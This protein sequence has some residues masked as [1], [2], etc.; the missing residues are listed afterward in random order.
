ME[1]TYFVLGMLTIAATILLTAVVVGLVKINKLTKQQETIN[2][3]YHRDIEDLHRYIHE[4]RT[5]L[6]RM[7][8]QE[9]EL[10]R[11]QTEHEIQSIHRHEDDIHRELCREIE[12][13]KKYVDSRI[14]KTIL[15]GS[16]KGSK[17][18]ING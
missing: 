14:D 17:Q 4:M 1:T 15:S 12:E 11:K 18:V 13:T 3:E 6:H 16:F 10:T 2:T 9:V 8:E 7:I 5:D